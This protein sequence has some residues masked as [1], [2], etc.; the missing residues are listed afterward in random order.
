[1]R[2]SFVRALTVALTGPAVALAGL[3]G[4][5]SAAPPD[6]GT[7]EETFHDDV[8]DNFCDSGLTVVRDGTFAGR[9]QS[10]ARGEDGLQY[11]M[12]HVRFEQVV[13]NPETGEYV[14]EVHKVTSKDLRVTDNGDGTLTILV[15]A[16]GNSTLYNSAGRAI[17]RNPGQIRFEFLIDNAG[18]PSDPSD[19]EFLEFLG[20]VKESTGRSDDYCAAV[21]SAIA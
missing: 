7:F 20:V 5:A 13:T 21:L 4:P 15:L 6:R 3:V 2:K 12:E 14:R 8:E 18:T 10:N 11:Y 1:M 9:F 17:A 16:T 19:D